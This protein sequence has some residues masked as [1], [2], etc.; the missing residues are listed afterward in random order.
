ML[1]HQKNIILALQK[2]ESLILKEVRKSIQWLKNNEVCDFEKWLSE[3]L[4]AFYETNLKYLFKN[5]PT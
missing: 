5:I 1:E 2:E 3:L 4:P